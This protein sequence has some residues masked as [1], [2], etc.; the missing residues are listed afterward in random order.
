MLRIICS[1]RNIPNV[2]ML[3]TKYVVIT[4]IHS[5]YHIYLINYYY[6]NYYDNFFIV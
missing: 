5:Y 1:Q 6:D 4:G 2:M 3:Y